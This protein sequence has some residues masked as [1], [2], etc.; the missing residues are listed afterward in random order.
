LCFQEKVIEHFNQLDF[1]RADLRLGQF[2]KFQ[3]VVPGDRLVGVDVPNAV[4]QPPE[5]RPEVIQFD[6]KSRKPE[7]GFILGALLFPAR[8]FQKAF[9]PLALRSAVAA[10]GIKRERALRIAL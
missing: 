5:G 10:S 7:F 8:P 6:R 4:P 3:D 1:V 2:P 9:K